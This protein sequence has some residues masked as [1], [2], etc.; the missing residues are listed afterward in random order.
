MIE[1]RAQRLGVVILGAGR[2][3]RMGRPKL[4]LPWGS[5]S[6]VGHLIAQWQELGARQIALVCAPE[7]A[8]LGAELDR[9][10]FSPT[11]RIVNPAPERGMFSS[12]QCAARWAG[13]DPELIH[14]A[15][16]LGDQPHLRPDTLRAVVK[17][18]LAAPDEICQPKYGD[19]GRHPVVLPKSAFRQLPDSSARNLKE[20]LAARSRPVVCC[21]I[22][23]PGLG[24]DLD[25]PEDYERAARSFPANR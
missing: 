24:F 25:R 7:D 15:I 4:L 16:V 18:S 22:D 21:A 3:A 5:K 12:I 1:A 6:I 8:A 2:S 13:W 20:F 17:C 19:H 14:W 11:G 23:D 10:G 9:L